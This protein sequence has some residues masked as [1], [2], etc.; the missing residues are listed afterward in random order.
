M[1]V[2]VVV[3]VV[4]VSERVRVVKGARFSSAVEVSPLVRLELED[5]IQKIY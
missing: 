2:A 4:F 3:I 5:S 1:E